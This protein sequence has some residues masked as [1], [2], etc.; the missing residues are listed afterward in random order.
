MR[1]HFSEAKTGRLRLQ[2]HGFRS[3]P[4]EIGVLWC[5]AVRSSSEEQQRGKEE[6]FSLPP[7]LLPI[8][9]PQLRNKFPFIRARG[10]HLWQTYGEVVCNFRKE[11][12]RNTLRLGHQFEGF[13]GA[14]N[15][16]ARSK[17]LRGGFT[18]PLA[19]HA[20]PV[21][22]STREVSRK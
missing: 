16:R 2:Y 19:R 1:Q 5:E 17:A 15:S 10:R 8:H 13:A 22:E 14:M 6:Y 7:S 21:Q 11:E 18:Y 3:L 9:Q 12:R 20:N 4:G